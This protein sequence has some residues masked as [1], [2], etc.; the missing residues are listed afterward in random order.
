MI[1]LITSLFFSLMA[2]K[3]LN[4]LRVFPGHKMIL[5]ETFFVTQGCWKRV[6]LSC[7]ILHCPV[8]VSLNGLIIYFRI[9]RLKIFNFM[10]WFFIG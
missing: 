3:P 8:L 2:F 1:V 6:F 9:I 7:L 5:I 4:C 10:Q